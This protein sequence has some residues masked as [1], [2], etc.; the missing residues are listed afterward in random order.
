MIKRF[1]LLFALIVLPTLVF[2]QD[3]EEDETKMVREIVNVMVD[4]AKFAK[5]PTPTASDSHDKKGHKKHQEETTP[6]VAD[7]G[8]STIPAPA[9]EIAKRANNWYNAK[10]KKYVKA[11]GANS[12]STV[13]CNVTFVYK[14]KVLNPENDV[15][16]HITMDVIIDAK[17]GKYRYTIKNIKH[18]ANK[19]GN[20]GGDIYLK[21]P[22]AGS[23]K[24][25]DLTWKHIRSAAFADIQ[26]VVD[27]LKAKM[28]EDGDAKK[29]DDW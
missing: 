11:N 17:E 2:S 7:T 28:K 6:P 27:D 20:S 4:K 5:A 8:A 22:E 29:K 1:F 21:V 10:T 25:V 23:M 15:D 3:A 16:G 18:K 14:Q 9:G 13:N 19:E 24:I 12:G 26:M